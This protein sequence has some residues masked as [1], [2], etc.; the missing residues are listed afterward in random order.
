MLTSY[1]S[2][3]TEAIKKLEERFGCPYVIADSFRH[4]LE[5]WPK[6]QANNGEKLMEYADFLQQCEIAFTSV[7]QLSKLDDIREMKYFSN[8]LPKHLINKWSTKAGEKNRSTKVYPLFSEY[9]EFVYSEA[10]LA[11]DSNTSV[12][13]ILAAGRQRQ[14]STPTKDSTV[15]KTNSSEGSSYSKKPSGSVFGTY[16]AICHK[17]PEL[18]NHITA[19]CRL[20]CKMPQSELLEFISSA[21]LCKKCLRKGHTD[22]ACNTKRRCRV[23]KLTNH[24][25][26]QH[27]QI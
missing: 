3:Y 21:K 20:V 17:C 22:D 15:N 8:T 24:C 18:S 23:C 12:S 6:I 19:D 16:K 2:A 7:P 11:T 26:F 14:R 5:A 1:P 9:V 4:K 27:I 13:A 25:S 10:I